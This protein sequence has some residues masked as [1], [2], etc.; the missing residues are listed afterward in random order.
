MKLNL[1]LM[2]LT[3][4]AIS[5]GSEA[6]YGQNSI[7]SGKIKGRIT[8]QEKVV[9][10]KTVI[11]IDAEEKYESKGNTIEEIEYKDGKIDK[12]MIY[13]YDSNN[14]KIKETELG[15]SGKPVK[16]GEYKYEN[17]LRKEKYIYDANKK[18]LSKKTYTYNY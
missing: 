4:A 1:F 12:H 16:I 18:L 13:E 6:V 5:I 3:V 17:G 2:I 14:N 10:G 8:R 15:P 7:S 11:S 9:K